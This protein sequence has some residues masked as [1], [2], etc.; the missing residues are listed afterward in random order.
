[1]KRILAIFVCLMLL[2]GA[3]ACTK[4]P[5]QTDGGASAA[6]QGDA[7]TFT[8]KVEELKDWMITATDQEGNAFVFG[9]EDVDTDQIGLGDTVTITYTGDITDIGSA[10]TASAV[11]KVDK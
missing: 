8:G 2:L 11:E 4:E 5:S 9:T 6:G 7:N 3:G 1:M 10:L